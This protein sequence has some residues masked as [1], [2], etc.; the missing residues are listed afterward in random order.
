MTDQHTRIEGMDQEDILVEKSQHN[1]SDG[2]EAEAIS[3]PVVLLEVIFTLSKIV[4]IV[5][6]IIVVVLSVI[7]G[8]SW[9]EITMRAALT[10]LVLGSLMWLINYILLK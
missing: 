8:C 2:Q 9:F 1:S 7:A 4:T 6:G 5:A 3:A 10:V